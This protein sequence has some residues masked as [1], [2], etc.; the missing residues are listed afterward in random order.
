MT[1][2]LSAEQIHELAE[3]GAVKQAIDAARRALPLLDGTP[4]A[5]VLLA[6]SGACLGAGQ[7]IEALRAAVAASELFEAGRDA[8][9]RCDALLRIA[10][11]LAGAGDDTA[12]VTT[13]E[14]AEMLAREMGDAPRLALALRHVGVCCSRLGRHQQALACLN[15]ATALQVHA[16]SPAER[17]ST[18]LALCHA[19]S[20]HA[21]SLPAGSAAQQALRDDTIDLWPPLANDCAAAGLVRLEALARANH[22]F[23]L[24][25]SGRHRDA[26]ALLEA[27]VPSYRATGQ[28]S[29][30]G[31][32]HTELGR[33]HAALG[34]ALLARAYFEE[35]AGI[36]R[37]SGSLDDL[38]EALEGLSEAEESLG[39][40]AAALAALK[41]A[42]AIDR[43]K[44]EA[45]ARQRMLQRELRIELARLT[46]P[47]KQ[48]T[49][50]DPLTGLANRRALDAWMAERLPRVEQGEPLTLLLLDIDHFKQINEGHGTG[51]GDRVLQRLAE[52]LRH[53]CR[54]RDL[55]V[56]YGGEEF[57]LAL[58]SVGHAEAVDIAHRVRHGVETQDWSTLAS[59]LRVAVSIG[60]AEATEALD[61]TMLL[62]LA[63]RRLLSAKVAGR[64][65][66][67]VAG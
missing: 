62:A 37:A 17:L 25:Q 14:Q 58:A 66:V 67:V 30:E 33:C 4:R 61:A 9:G 48:R 16:V 44:D 57:L 8:A 15:E 18:R 6:L 5:H 43:R 64:N 41:E 22:G 38:L 12:A 26:A 40:P 46:G 1:A 20:R 32:C 29:D 56:R 24:R 60:V 39:D 35:A 34:D 63:D 10:A 42:R 21:E 3:Q 2:M 49:V 11:A 19:R 65:Q 50:T 52:V 28:R 53:A 7:A 27:L 31:L 45:M 13:I 47:W 59:G 54:S 51:L 55:A 36:L 23:L